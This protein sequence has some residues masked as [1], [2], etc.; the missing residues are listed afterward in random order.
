MGFSTTQVSPLE[1]PAFNGDQTSNT[2]SVELSCDEGVPLAWISAYAA[3]QNADPFVLE[4]GAPALLEARNRV[5]INIDGTTVV[6]NILLGIGGYDENLPIPETRIS[7]HLPPRLV[8]NLFVRLLAA[9][10][11]VISINAL[12]GGPTATFDLSVRNDDWAKL[13]AQCP[14]GQFPGS[15]PLRECDFAETWKEACPD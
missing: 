1:V 8:P 12:E 6:D 10:S 5:R 2:M 15:E 9:K 11:A 13:T 3:F 7:Y 4:P 14:N